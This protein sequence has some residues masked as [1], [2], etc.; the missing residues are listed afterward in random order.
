[1]ES[2]LTTSSC[3][4]ERDDELRRSPTSPGLAAETGVSD[5]GK[6]AGTR[7][8]SPWLIWRSRRSTPSGSGQHR[9][10]TGDKGWPQPTQWS[11]R[12]T[13]TSFLLLLLLVVAAV[14][15]VVI[16]L[17]VVVAVAASR[18][19]ARGRRW[20]WRR[21]RQGRHRRG[22]TTRTVAGATFPLP[23][24][25]RRIG[26]LS[27]HPH[28]RS[29]AGDRLREPAG[30][31]ARPGGKTGKLKTQEWYVS[32][33]R[34]G[35][36]QMLSKCRVQDVQ[37][38]LVGWMDGWAEDIPLDAVHAAAVTLAPYWP[39]QYYSIRAVILTG[40]QGLRQ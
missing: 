2:W 27:W 7:S 32:S 22:L 8:R 39:G 33:S 3:E 20:M 9:F 19:V 18:P 1:M 29:M 12:V 6:G 37:H 25:G 4:N 24:A 14:V 15:M 26:I 10:S 35:D 17:L 36:D 13:R 34:V 40:A 38:G 21:R 5:L 23:Q 16:L 30:G 11:T 31:R 28:R